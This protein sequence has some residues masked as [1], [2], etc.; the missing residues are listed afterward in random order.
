MGRALVRE[1]GGGEGPLKLGPPEVECFLALECPK[2][3]AKFAV[4]IV[5][6]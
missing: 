4:F 3:A 1:S 2:K 5:S 6:G